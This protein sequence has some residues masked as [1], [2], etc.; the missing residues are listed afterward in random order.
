MTTKDWDDTLK[1]IRDLA[2]VPDS[3]PNMESI[4]KAIHALKVIDEAVRGNGVDLPKPFVGFINSKYSRGVTLAWKNTVD[5]H[6]LVFVSGNQADVGTY[7]ELCDP[8][9]YGCT[10]APWPTDDLIAELAPRAFPTTRHIE[11]PTE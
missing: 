6:G 1:S 11:G 8:D 4:D 10:C 5:G 2:T 9:V 7:L 3:P